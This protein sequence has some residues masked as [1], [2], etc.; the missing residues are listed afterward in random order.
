MAIQVLTKNCQ[1]IPYEK[2]SKNFEDTDELSSDLNNLFVQIFKQMDSKERLSEILKNIT[3]QEISNLKFEK[4]QEVKQ[5]IEIQ[6]NIT[7]CT[8]CGKA[9]GDKGFEYNPET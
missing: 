2:I 3:E 9:I 8:F 5:F 4:F 6:E 1:Y 7:L